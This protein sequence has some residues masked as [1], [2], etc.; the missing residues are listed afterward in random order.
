MDPPA[1]GP[2]LSVVPSIATKPGGGALGPQWP[3]RGPRSLGQTHTHT[4]THT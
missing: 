3:P 4:H 2:L 1:E